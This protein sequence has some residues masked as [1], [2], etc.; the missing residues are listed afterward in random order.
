M[1]TCLAKVRYA[2]GRRLAVGESK[3]EAV[4]Y[5]MI[6]WGT[7]F[8]GMVWLLSTGI[9]AG[10]GG[11]VG[12]ASGA[13]TVS[14]D[15]ADDDA[16]PA[17]PSS[18]NMVD[19]LR[20]RYDSELGNDRF[21]EDLKKAGLSEEQA[22]KAQAEVKSNMDRLRNDPTQLPEVARDLANK[23][24]VR[25]VAGRAAEGAR[26]ATWWTLIGMLISMATVIAGSLVGA[27]ELLQPVPILGVRRTEVVGERSRR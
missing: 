3:L 2:T 8:I 9:R 11:M 17:S 21:V 19:A 12:M 23:P 15:M 6:L 10:F 27:G 16:T 24:E 13:Y 20:R 18:S 22:K 4:L 25:E 5:G 7:L 1:A 26:S 14:R